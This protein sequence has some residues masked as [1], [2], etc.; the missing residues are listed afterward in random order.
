MSS[1]LVGGS[2]AKRSSNEA[3]GSIGAAGSSRSCRFEHQR[4]AASAR[5]DFNDSGSPRYARSCSSARGGGSGRLRSPRFPR[6]RNLRPAY[7]R[8]SFDRSCRFRPTVDA[9]PAELAAVRGAPWPERGL[10]YARLSARRSSGPPPLAT[11][12]RAS[13][14][15]AELA[16]PDELR[17]SAS[18][19]RSR[20]VTPSRHPRSPRRRRTRRRLAVRPG[21]SS[22]VHPR[23]PKRS[24]RSRLRRE[25]D[26][27]CRRKF[28]RRP[29]CD[30][31][32][33]RRRTLRSPA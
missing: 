17:P 20:Q 10:A 12:S 22:V 2:T 15:P 31:R 29:G 9:V 3:A 5:H 7:A 16:D 8:H 21:R 14:R 19:S 23:A 26:A 6:R 13:F 24:R 32:V 25:S 28:Q 27:G 4:R 11:V 18:L 1:S 33:P 30:W